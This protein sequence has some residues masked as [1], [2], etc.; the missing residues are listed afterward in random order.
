MRTCELCRTVGLD[1]E[2]GKDETEE[3]NDDGV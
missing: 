2:I 3:G 1:L